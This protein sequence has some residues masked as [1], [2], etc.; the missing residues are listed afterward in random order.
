MDEWHLSVCSAIRHPIDMSEQSA[1]G[2]PS[3]WAKSRRPVLVAVTWGVLE[4][5]GMGIAEIFADEYAGHF[6]RGLP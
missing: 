5:C 2:K 3:T 1:I 4:E 6:D